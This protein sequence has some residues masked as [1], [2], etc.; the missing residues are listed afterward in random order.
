[1][2][3]F[4]R[5]THPDQPVPK[6]G[7]SFT[8]PVRGRRAETPLMST[9]SQIRAMNCHPA[10]QADAL[11]AAN[12]LNVGMRWRAWAARRSLSRQYP[13]HG[14]SAKVASA[15]AGQR[16]NQSEHSCQDQPEHAGPHPLIGHG[17]FL[18]DESV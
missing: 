16:E 12:A 9:A 6:A 2:T 14:K 8:R 3:N 5:I 17:S 1:M 18:P 10:G 15:D 13:M 11:L 4:S 7:R